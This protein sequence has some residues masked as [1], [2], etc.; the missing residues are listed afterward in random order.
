LA[1]WYEKVWDQV[2]SGAAMNRVTAALGL[3]ALLV[4]S[5]KAAAEDISLTCQYTY[6]EMN[7]VG[8]ISADDPFSLD[9]SEQ[10]VHE[11]GETNLRISTAQ[12]YHFI[13]V[14]PRRIAYGIHGFISENGVV[15]L[16][17]TVNINRVT[18][19]IAWQRGA[20]RMTGSC[21]KA[22]SSP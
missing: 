4:A 13:S 17:T 18:G 10:S 16:D 9:I 1:N 21:Q 7:G 3:I 20:N 22:G 2:P 8:S 14:S 5:G 6:Q 15:N 12:P 19:V 11:V